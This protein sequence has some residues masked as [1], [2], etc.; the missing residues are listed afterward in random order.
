[1]STSLAILMVL[2]F[3]VLIIGDKF[4]TWRNNKQFEIWKDIIRSLNADEFQEQVNIND[5]IIRYLPEKS[6]YVLK[7]MIFL[8]A[9]K[10]RRR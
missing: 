10:D 2:T 4:L 6:N 1:M 5:E 7:T 8:R 9:E 3:S